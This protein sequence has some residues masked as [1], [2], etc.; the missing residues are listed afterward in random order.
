MSFIY[1]IPGVFWGKESMSHHFDSSNII[2][3]CRHV[4]KQKWELGGKLFKEVHW[5]PK[6]ETTPVILA[7][8]RA[9]SIALHDEWEEELSAHT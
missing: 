5:S 2:T 8:C 4:E 9:M 3:A 1:F 6:P 7:R